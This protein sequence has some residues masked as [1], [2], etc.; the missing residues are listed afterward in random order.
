MDENR[1]IRI[2][3]KITYHFCKI[4]RLDQS[5]SSCRNNPFTAYFEIETDESGNKFLKWDAHR[6]GRTYADWDEKEW[7]EEE[8]TFIPGEGIDFSTLYS[9]EAKVNVSLSNAIKGSL[10]INYS[11]ISIMRK[12]IS[13]SFEKFF[14]AELKHGRNM[15]PQIAFDSEF[16]A[17]FSIKYFVG[18]CS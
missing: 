6:L 16:K 14:S 17:K 7:D 11:L 12:K 10:L 13:C 18:H 15:V 4:C 2:L 9:H 3:L 5:V 8:E 1:L